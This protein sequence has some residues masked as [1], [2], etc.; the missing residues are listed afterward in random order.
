MARE[1]V[2]SRKIAGL[3]VRG[4]NET[5]EITLP[6]TYAR[7]VIPARHRQI[8]RPESAR[9]WS[10]LE[11]I[12]EF[13]MP[14]RNDVVV[15]LLI[16]TNC[17]RAIKPWEIIPGNDDDPYAKRTALGWG[18]IGI[19]EAKVNKESDENYVVVNRVITHEANVGPDR[20]ICHLAL[21]AQVKEIMI[22]PSMFNQM[23]ELD[24]SERRKEEQPLSY[25]DKMFIKKVKKGIH[26]RE[27][28]HYEIPLPFKDD[29][30]KLPN[31][32]G[33]ALSRLSKLKQ[34]FLR[35]KKY[36]TDYLTFMNGIIASNYAELV[37]Q[38]E[39]ELDDGRIWYLP[40]HGVY[41]HRKPDKI[42]VVFDCSAVYK[43]Q[44]LN[45]NLLLGPDLTN[46]LLGVLCRFRQDNT[47]FMCDLEA[48]FHQVM[49]NVNDR[50][51]LRFLW[52]KGGDLD[53][54]PIVYR[55]TAH[56]FGATSSPGCANVGLKTTAD[57][58][59]TEC[60]SQAANF[61][62]DNF[63]V[64]DGLKSVSTPSNAIDLIQ[65]TKTLCKKGGFRLHKII[66]N[67]KEV[68][69]AIPPEERA[70]GIQ[71]LDPTRDALPIE[72]A[73]GVQWCV[74]FDTFKFR[75]ELADRPLTRR[76]ILSTVS[77]VFDPLGVLAPFVL[78]GKR[79]LQEL[80]R[81]GANWD[82]KI[83]DY[84]LA[85]WERWRNDVV[86]LAKLSIPRCY[87]P[88]DFGEIKVVEMHNFSVASEIGYGQ[89]SYLRLV[90]HLGRI[91]CSLVLAKSRVAPLKLVT[92]PRLELTAALVTA[93]VGA[94][95]KRE[96]EYEQVNEF[97]W[98]D[99]KVVL[100]Y[101]F[102]SARRFHVFV[103]NRIEQIRDLTSLAQ[104]RYV[105]SK[106]NPADYAS[107]GLHA[108]D[109][110][111]KKEWWHGPDF[112]WNNFDTQRGVIENAV[113][114]SPDDPDV[115]KTSTLVTEVKELADIE[116]CLRRFSSWYQAK[117]A[118]SFCLPLRKR[119]TNLLRQKSSSPPMVTSRSGKKSKMTG[120]QI[121]LVK[122]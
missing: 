69:E 20:R 7:E 74:E 19:V 66:S 108:Q 105:E 114:V 31:N 85:R 59:E 25:E 98:S 42:R 119:L 12:A 94:L 55:M 21:R 116:E 121:P 101:I 65:K 75:I 64:D 38:E 109:L 44:S 57:D 35:D 86:L 49:V 78:I 36:Q 67:S 103:A 118:I 99:S 58:Y 77:S 60:G 90:D 63:Y 83:P 100:G 54:E 17:A 6:G 102:N 13:F 87:V 45:Q 84:L 61:V 18:I 37:P 39:M 93:K 92:I 46:S 82:D 97:F 28:G 10:H 76:G 53:N 71:D 22:N 111:D 9:K 5:S 62:R 50:N 16:G 81:D 96:L 122:I 24:F 106:E 14:F 41:H 70:K 23:F 30:V 1:T 34:R 3:T 8:P 33:Q 2:N 72:R 115:R 88:D 113:A 11:K 52:W 47:A 27:D 91:H 51:F 32:K 68:I 104:W 112:L 48:M 95:L 26:Q 107:R 73:L 4:V 117:R 80:C 15:G 43:G 110:I 40:H 120:K 29:E 56:L 89:C 79:I